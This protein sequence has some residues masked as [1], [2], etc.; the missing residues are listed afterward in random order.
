MGM[1]ADHHRYSSV[2]VP[3]HGYFLAGQLSVKIHKANF[4]LRRDRRQNLIGFTERT[5]RRRHMSPALEIDDGAFNTISG[6]HQGPTLTRKFVGIVGGTQ[7]PRLMRK[8]FQN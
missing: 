7:E 4:Y 8:V 5:V 3:S 6:F 1:G 2:Q